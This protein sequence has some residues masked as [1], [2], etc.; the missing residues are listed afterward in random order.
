MS[1]SETQLISRRREA[2]LAS[3]QVIT[4][5]I[6]A[7]RS[8]S[9]LRKT[10]SNYNSCMVMHHLIHTLRALPALVTLQWIQ[11]A[12][13][14][15]MQSSLVSIKS[16]RVRLTETTWRTKRDALSFQPSLSLDSIQIATMILRRD[17]MEMQQNRRCSLASMPCLI[18]T[19]TKTW[20]WIITVRKSS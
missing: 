15:S 3:V 7:S 10:I 5:I 6:R 20:P 4:L 12:W 19:C 17:T 2:L 1:I 13:T 8:R 18:Q 9:T 14:L 11:I 16:S